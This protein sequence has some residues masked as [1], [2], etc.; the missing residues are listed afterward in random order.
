MAKKQKKPLGIIDLI[1]MVLVVAGIGVLAYPFV[2]DAYV[3][4][5][6][7][8]VIDSYQVRETNK[9]QAALKKEYRRYQAK[10]RELAAA[11]TAPGVSSF[12]AAV[13]D[14]GTA[15]TDA[16][17]NQKKLAGD[18]IAQLTIP[19]IG[20]SL[21]V[22]D[23]TTDWLL[24]FGAC[25]LDGTSYPTGGPGTHAV[26]SGHRGVP[27]AELFTRLP[28]LGK[29][30]K[31]Y[32]KIGNKTLAYQVFKREVIEP[33]DVSKLRIAPGE[34]LVTLMTCTPYMINSQRLLITGRRV[35][36]TKADAAAAE[37]AT[38]W[39]KAKLYV[40]ALAAL[41]LLG[42]LAA[43][44]RGLAIGRTRYELLLP[45]GFASATVSRGRRTRAFTPGDDG[46]IRAELPGNRYKVQATGDGAVV[47]YTAYIGRLRDKRFTLRTKGEQS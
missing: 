30:D 6:N 34:D 8:Q 47:R 28:E 40:W 46:L 29:G 41:A 37:R 4:H 9:N 5:K 20:A 22:F 17:R 39:N 13:N 16:K 26:I 32:I 44:L 1:I 33:T 24:Q 10:N 3:S 38:W 25:L 18:T 7:Q 14:Q 23:H 45:A 27:N 2:S 36:Y 12:N 19:K 31:F 35:P 11:N 43:M 21:P 15:N 42:L